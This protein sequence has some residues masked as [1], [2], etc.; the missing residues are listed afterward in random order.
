[1]DGKFIAVRHQASTPDVVSIVIDGG[2]FMST[3]NGDL[4][5]RETE[6]LE[7]IEA[8]LR[9]LQRNPGMIAVG[10]G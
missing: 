4:W 10:W 9:T 7:K 8:G 6:D 5:F 1:M 2:R 3:H